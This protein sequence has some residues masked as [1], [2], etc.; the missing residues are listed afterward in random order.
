MKLTSW[1]RNSN[2]I[3][4][5]MSV[6]PSPAGLSSRLSS[7]LRDWLLA[8]GSQ[9]LCSMSA[10]LSSSLDSQLHSNSAPVLAQLSIYD[11]RLLALTALDSTLTQFLSNFHPTDSRLSLGSVRFGSQFVSALCPVQLSVRVSSLLGSALG[12][13]RLSVRLSL[14]SVRLSVRLCAGSS[15]ALSSLCVGPGAIITSS[16]MVRGMPAGGRGA[17]PPY[18]QPVWPHNL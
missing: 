6:S 8:D 4:K 12:S 10:W 15:S 16:V 7:Q 11:S 17:S 13:A 18:N 2:Q 5:M 1:L 9:R 14:C 3:Q